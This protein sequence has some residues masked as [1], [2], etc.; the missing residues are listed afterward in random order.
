VFL[1]D[2]NSTPLPDIVASVSAVHHVLDSALCGF[3]RGGDS[4]LLALLMMNLLPMTEPCP[5]YL[6]TTANTL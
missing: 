6:P 4:F 5:S 2:G 1:V 3:S